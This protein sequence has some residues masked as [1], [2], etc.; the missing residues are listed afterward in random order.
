MK[1]LNKKQIE[2]FAK[3]IRKLIFKNLREEGT[4]KRIKNKSLA[5]VHDVIIEKLKK[6]HEI[7]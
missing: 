5:K 1:K 2:G 7:I 3:E 4:R 6:I